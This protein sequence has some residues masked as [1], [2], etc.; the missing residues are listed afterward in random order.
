M[1]AISP[2]P[3]APDLLAAMTACLIAV[4]DMALLSRGVFDRFLG[5]YP[6]EAARFINVD[7]AVL[8][9][10]DETFVLLHGLA[11]GEG[12]VG[13]PR[14]ALGRSAPQL[15]PDC[16]RA[17][18]GLDGAVSGRVASRER[19]G[20]GRGVKRMAGRRRCARCAAG[21]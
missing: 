9:M 1:T 6:D 13:G 16:Q 11:S 2:L 17:L 19:R 4:P 20:L 10:T 5:A 8:R 14:G 3:V 15:W 7:A 18:S 12:W 21:R